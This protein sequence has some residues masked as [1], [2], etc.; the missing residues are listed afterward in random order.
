[1][2]RQSPDDR[3]GSIE[4]IKD[5][6]EPADPLFEYYAAITNDRYRQRVVQLRLEEEAAPRRSLQ[7][8]IAAEERRQRMLQSLKL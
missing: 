4:E 8:K 5:A 2:V 1:M 6:L 7:E 3:P